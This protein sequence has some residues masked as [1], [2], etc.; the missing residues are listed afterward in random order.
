MG[1]FYLDRSAVQVKSVK[2]KRVK[3]EEE[4]KKKQKKKKREKR[5]REK[6]ICWRRRLI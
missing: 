1:L 2:G 3:E 4:E 5:K 6:K